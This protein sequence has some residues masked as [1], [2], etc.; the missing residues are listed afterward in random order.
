MN[1]FYTLILS[2]LTFTLGINAQ[3]TELF[4]SE[5]A[6]GT[7]NNKYLEIYNGTSSTISLDNYAFPSVSNAPNTPGQY[8]FWNTFPTG[9]SIA[10]G[11]V[12]VIAHPSADPSISAHADH[13]HQ[14]LSNG[15]DGYAL[16]SGG[17]HNDADGDG[18][19]D[20]G[21]MTGFTLLD[22]IGN[23]GGDP[24][25]AWD[26]AGV[27]NAT[28]NHTLVR[29]PSVT[30]PN[31]CWDQTCGNSSAGTNATD[32]EWIVYP[33][34]TWTYL[35][36][37]STILQDF[38]S[39]Q[40]VAVVDVFGAFG[41]GLAAS[42]VLEDDPVAGGSNKVRKATQSAGGDIWKGVFFRP[43]SHYIDLTNNQTVSINVYSTTAT[44]FKGKIQAG[45]SSQADIELTTSQPHTGSGW[46][47]LS[48]D[49]TGATGE[50]GELVLFVN[51]DANGAFID[52]AVQAFDVFFDDI[53][54]NQGSAIPAPAAGPTNNAAD[55]TPLAADV[56]SIFSDTYTDVSGSDFN[57]NWGQSGHGSVNASFDPG[58][59]N[60][61]LAYTNFNYQGIQFGSNQDISPMEYLHVDIWVE[62]TFNPRVFVIS[63][64]TEV[65]HT[66]TNTGAN[67]WISADIPVTGITGN[68]SNCYQF[69]FDGGNG[70]TDA[71]YVDN[72]YFWRTPGYNPNPPSTV[73]ITFEVNTANI[74]NNAQVVGANG[75]YVGGGVVG[76][77]QAI[78]LTQST[79]DTLL[80]TGVYTAPLSL[81]SSANSSAYILLNSPND[82]ADWGKK[83]DLNGLPCGAAP[84]NDRYFP[85][86]TSDTT[87]KLC[88][89]SC[90]T[91][92]S[93]PPPP[94]SPVNVTFQVDMSQYSGSQG[95]GYTTNLN[96][97]FNGWCG[98]CNPMSDPDGDNVWEITIPLIPG[99]DHR[100]KFT[101]NG[102]SDQENFSG[103]EPCTNTNS[104]G[105]T[106][107][108]L[109]IPT[110]DTTLGLVCFNSCSPCAPLN[111]CGVTGTY[112]YGDNEDAS[113][114]VGF[115][116]D[117][118]D[119][120]TL[121]FTA[122][123]TENNWD[124]WH[125]TDA[126]D[127][128]GN[129][130]ATDDGSIV[131]S[132]TSTTGEI[133]FYVDSDGSYS[134]AGNGLAGS[135]FVYSVSCSAPPACPDPSGLAA[136]NI[137]SAG[138]DI[139]WTAGGTESAWNLEYGAPGFTQG[140]GT[141]VNVTSNPYS[142]T[143][144]TANTAYDVYL[145]ADCGSGDV[146]AWVG[147]ISFTTACITVSTF[148]YSHGFED[149]TCWTNSSSSTPWALDAGDDFGPNTVTEGVSAVFFNDYDYSTGST[150]DL[151][152]PFL[153]FSSLNV[154]RLSFDYWDGSNSDVVDVLVDAGSGPVVVYT[155]NSSVASWTNIVVDLPSY[156]GQTV[157]VGFRGT[158]VYGYTNPHIDNLV[159]Q[160]A[161][162]CVE[163]NS[164]TANNV[165]TSSA[166]LSW[167]AVGTETTWNLKWGPTGGT[168]TTVV[169]SANPTYSL[170]GLTP[171]TAYEYSVQAVCGS[172]TSNYTSSFTFTTLCDL[173]TTFPY[174]QDFETS[175][176]CWDV[177]DVDGGN[178]W[179]R[180]T[181]AGTNG[182]I[183]AGI[184]YNLTA[185]DDHL[186]SP[187]FSVTANSSR[188]SFNA[189][190]YGGF[191][192]SFEV[193][194][195]TTGKLAAD[196]TDTISSEV[197]SGGYSY[198]Q[199]DLSSYIGGNIYVSI[200]S[201]STNQYYLF[202]DDVT[203]DA[204]VIDTVNQTVSECDSYDWFGTTY[205]SSGVYT[206][207]VSAVDV[208][209]IDSLF[210]LNLTINNSSATTETVTACDSYTWAGD[211][212][213]YSATGIYVANLQT[214]D[215]CDS[216]AT[217]DLTITNSSSS[218]ETVSA[219]DS[220]TWN[221]LTFTT[222]GNQT[223]TLTNSVGCDSVANLVLTIN[224]STS[225]LLTTSS[226]NSYDWNG[227]TYTASGMY[228]AT[229]VNSFGCPQIDS[230]DL[231]ITTS[232]T[233]LTQAACDSFAWNGNN[234]TT[235]GTYTNASGSCVDTLF[236]TVNS[237]SSSVTN[238]VVCDSLNWNGI[239]YLASGSYTYLTTNASGCDSLASLN[240]TVNNSVTNSLSLTVCDH[241]IW[242]GDT[243]TASGVYV[244][245][246]QTSSSC[247]SV[248]TVNLT[249]NNSD[250][251]TVT[252]FACEDYTWNGNTYSSTGNYTDT[253][254]SSVTGCDSIVTL[255]LTINVTV[256]SF[257]ESFD[258]IVGLPT[259]W[260]QDTS[261][262]FDWSLNSGPTGSGGTGPSSDV[263]GSGN[264]MYIETS[265][266]RIAGDVAI[267]HTGNIDIGNLTNPELRFFSHMY[268]SAIGTLTVELWDGTSYNTVFTKSGDHGDQWNEE[269]VLLTSS[270]NIV[271]FRITAVTD[272]NSAGDVWPGD[273]AIDEFGVREAL[274][275]DLALVAAAVSSDCELTATEPV[276]VWVVNEGLVA[277]TGFDLSFGVNGAAAT[278]E[279]VT[280]TLNPGDT[281]MYV[282]NATADMSTD[283]MMY[284]F[285]FHVDL[286]T[287][288]D[289]LDNHISASGENI[290]TPL[291]PTVMGDTICNGDTAMISANANGYVTW[292]DAATGGN[293]VGE[294]EDL[295]VSPTATTSYFAETKDAIAYFQD[296][297]SFNDGDLISV[298]DGQYWTP[299]PAATVTPAAVTSSEGNGGNSLLCDNAVVN[300]PVLE[301]GEAISTGYFY[302][303]V[304]MKI[305]DG[306]YFNMQENVAIGTA[307]SF[308]LVFDN[309]N[310]T[311]D[312]SID[313][314]SVLTGSYT[315]TNPT[316]DPV[317]ITVELEV[318]YDTGTWELFINGNSIGTFV[319]FDPV[320]S[321]NFY[322]RP[323]PDSDVYY[324]DNIEFFALKDDACVSTTR[325]EAVV[326]VEDCSNINELS[327]KDLNIYPNPNNG[328]FTIANSELISE[329]FI[330]DLQGKTVYINTNVNSK[331]LNIEMDNL[332]RG[333]YMINIKTETDNIT[334]TIVVQ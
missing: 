75:I 322:P 6:E 301:Y 138:A 117:A 330:T 44:N 225:S 84:Y 326:T 58:T 135:T 309:P 53:S 64:G 204:Y 223:Q 209:D 126:A 23:W 63:G 11:D 159:I 136:N 249:I 103:G 170:T 158:S 12:Y 260:S 149:L 276:E 124:F 70:S 194:V 228:V 248:V 321:A 125:I 52:P 184:A 206:N 258:S 308:D 123:S 88:F 109:T 22:H 175:F 298:V 20:E 294:G 267:L 279:T 105:F 162:S 312:V 265:S 317:W 327:F 101:V 289:T 303:S 236:L 238:S 272:S 142:M 72:L 130:L 57:P 60:T 271:S 34:E 96:G 134:P 310:G 99:A 156:A 165:T 281:L 100:Y 325:T 115:T 328:Q 112:D 178:S 141:I 191:P 227:N 235:S 144:L 239:N 148:P 168:M 291:A 120:I 128:T 299:W 211:G 94:A 76:D 277:Q 14:Y 171:N 173:L 297:D 80:W 77:A 24:G 280:S 214:V 288:Q 313:Q 219:C 231:T 55:P 18:N 119:Y 66:I 127:G 181:A 220:Y 111:D 273:I 25:T 193:L 167:I 35:G 93:C 221:G 131:G 315:G 210:V 113:N 247:D 3:I 5:Y 216:T 74:Y 198:Y 186:I 254:T 153:D 114:A 208:T 4:F 155:T 49:F 172:D 28:A 195:S 212:N 15:D 118:G 201:T 282:F 89:G 21:E 106:D 61:V 176:G 332:E 92:G 145:Q 252:V 307:W 319:N 246:L 250:V 41:G 259:C 285:T 287:D 133:S 27:T 192:E 311:V 163:P 50:W 234:Y 102:W 189:S 286:S 97:T 257:S 73:D 161:P 157:Q 256:A 38:S 270:S 333:M 262:I 292:F 47:T 245:T 160:E 81:F 26:V 290:F 107:R 266:P 85:V 237:S 284:N 152:S 253:L 197:A 108:V 7:S 67:N 43:H 122:G 268:G 10:P 37:H 174:V 68:L 202:V 188:F 229:L 230:L 185:H 241:Y 83:E 86:I 90:E 323:A 318:D 121:N 56:I 2:V 269:L 164:L 179:G 274:A 30:G 71:I 244:D 9:A 233:S 16:V 187:Q 182:S 203:I 45:T 334:E 62:G 293:Q 98:G 19:I 91:D 183:G 217:L 48:F 331:N 42:N 78:L 224:S 1:K 275:N 137:T 59:G 232:S 242:N 17:T 261:D 218:T 116:A 129:T 13:T 151:M 79:T 33:N 177:L 87:L 51:V 213:T 295:M 199:Y 278:V 54:A 166:D 306:A 263:S 316:G 190:D 39:L 65:P 255:S 147:P 200:H 95:P 110:S 140:S 36:S 304:D 132:Y 143:G 314:T 146:S 243:L 222:S 251:D 283:D 264:Y 104:S 154:P 320:A 150:S 82:G 180:Y 296:F 305:I 205:S 46:E 207:L 69:K 302:F 215:G 40:N 226:C 240:L 196:F 29:K 32:S 139:S 324:L 169:V 31:P 8:E 329:V 300:D